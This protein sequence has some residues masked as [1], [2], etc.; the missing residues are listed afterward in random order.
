MSLDDRAADR[1]ANAHA[2]ALRRV[3]GREQLVHALAI[4]ANS[5]VSDTQPH[6]CSAFPF[7]PDQQVA[8]SLVDAGHRVRGIAD[9]IQHHLLDPVSYTHLTLPTSDLV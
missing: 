5:S 8:R 1:E 9:Q 7:R 3:E 2:A 4:E 6:A